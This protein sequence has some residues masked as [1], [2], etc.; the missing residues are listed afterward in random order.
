MPSKSVFRTGRGRMVP[1]ATTKNRAGGPAYQHTDEHALIQH[2]C[3][4][5]FNGTFYATA[6]QQFD[7]VFNLCAK[8]DPRFIAQVAV[9]SREQGFMKDM[10]AY[11]VSDLAVKAKAAE[12][13]AQ[14]AWKASKDARSKANGDADKLYKA[15]VEAQKQAEECARLFRAAFTRV[16]GNGRMA[17]GCAQILRSGAAGRKSFGTM[18][19][20]AFQEW[21]DRRTDKHLL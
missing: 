7:E 2:A 13:A 18:I 5:T 20:G 19:K 6:E 3:T 21:F 12:E 11:L 15:A 1:P 16:I 8:L 17:K 10:P 4:G 14:S 9:F